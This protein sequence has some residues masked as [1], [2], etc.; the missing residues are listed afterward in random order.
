M[1]QAT[2]P[3]PE[4]ARPPR[5][6]RWIPLSLRIFVALLAILT[7]VAGWEGLRIYR[8][9][10]AIRCI[11]QA[12]GML[13]A[14]PAGPEWLRSIVGDDRMIGYD[15]VSMVYFP[16]NVDIVAGSFLDRRPAARRRTAISEQV[17]ASIGN[18]SDVA[19]IDLSETDVTDSAL[20]YLV[21]LNGLHQLN[22]NGTDVGDAGVR[23]IARLPKLVYLH[24]NA[25]QVSDA[26]LLELK[27]AKY[28]GWLWVYG[29][30]VTDSGV[31]RLRQELPECSIRN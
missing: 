22:L 23:Q 28:L 9:H 6:K 1:S 25:T 16:G 19:D 12:G 3:R 21:N 7:A 2:S 29:T 27:R 10:V 26:G 14:Q 18:L 31:K 30:E 17:L 8:Q 5:L 24:L 20:T 13:I 4:T 11:R 15:R